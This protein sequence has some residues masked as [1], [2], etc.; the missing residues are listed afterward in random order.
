MDDNKILHSGN[1]VVNG[2]KV[3]VRQPLCPMP[4]KLL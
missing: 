4:C 1:Y 2:C 3:D